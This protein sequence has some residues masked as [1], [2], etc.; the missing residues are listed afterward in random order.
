MTDDASHLPPLF[1][2]AE[3]WQNNACISAFCGSEFA[4]AEGYRLAANALVEHTGG[5][6]RDLDFLIYPTVFLYRH[7]LELVLKQVI[8][9]HVDAIHDCVGRAWSRM[10]VLPLEVLVGRMLAMAP[11]FDARFR[12][13]YEEFAYKYMIKPRTAMFPEDE[14]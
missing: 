1:S 8:E 9:K 11:L 7:H 12:K 13:H 2:R 10:S 5:T 3:D 6:S 14:E 4:Y